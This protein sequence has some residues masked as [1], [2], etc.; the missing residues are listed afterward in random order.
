MLSEY[1]RIS[2]SIDSINNFKQVAPTFKWIRHFAL[3]FK[4]VAGVE[5]KTQLLLNQ[6]NTVEL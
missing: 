5:E 6:L 1:I 4:D 2:H 3:A